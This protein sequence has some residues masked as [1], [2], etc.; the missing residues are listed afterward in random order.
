MTIQIDKFLIL[1]KIN[2]YADSKRKLFSEPSK[3]LARDVLDVC[4]QWFVES[5]WKGED[6]SHYDTQREYCISMM[7]YVK[8][9]I[10]TSDITAQWFTPSYAWL[11]AADIIIHLCVKTV[12]E[13]Y[14]DKIL[15][16]L[17]IEI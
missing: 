2:Q 8:D 7:L 1:P 16:E 14:W 17:D 12:V 6:V 4:Q 3:I 13:T 5:P 15:K 10:D 9:K 11:Q